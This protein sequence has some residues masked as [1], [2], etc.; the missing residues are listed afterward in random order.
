[1][2]RRG[3]GRPG[4]VGT[5]ARTAVVAGTATAVSNGMSRHQAQKQQERTQNEFYEQQ[6]QDQQAAAQQQAMAQQT[7]AQQAAAPA[8][9][10]KIEQ[11]EKLADL[12]DRGILNDQEF[13]TEK[14]R[15]L[16]S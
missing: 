7:A 4:L 9:D 6:Y 11:L 15:I 1:M 8:G 2:I 16:G 3:I 14:R 13:E 10:D 12:K 5:V